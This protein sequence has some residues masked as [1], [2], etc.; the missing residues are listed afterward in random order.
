[1]GA[2]LETT[3]EWLRGVGPD[4]D[5][6]LSTRLRF[7]RNLSRFPFLGGPGGA[8]RAE[9]EAYV[10]DRLAETQK[11]LMYFP[12]HRMDALDRQI[13]VERHLISREH[14]AA[15]GERGAAVSAG[16]SVS[17]MVNEEDH[18]RVQAIRSAFQAEEAFEELAAFEEDLEKR[19]EF[20]FHPRFG[21]AT[22]CPTNLGTGLR[23]SVMLHLPGL[24]YSRQ[25][26]KILHSLQ[27]V[28]YNIRGFFG[29]GTSP[30]GDLFQISNQVCLGRTEREIVEDLKRFVPEIVG[31]ERG[32]RDRLHKD[33]RPFLEDK[34]W[35]ALAVLKNA[36]IL[37]TEETMELLSAVRLGINLGIL[38]GLKMDRINEIFLWSQPAHLQK[39]KGKELSEIERDIFRAEFIREKLKAA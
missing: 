11:K 39:L 13:L 36:R 35:R 38:T 14:A 31:V 37:S 3:G 25:V 21:Y 33:R 1:M 4:A 30:T 23:A 34:A 20:S 2:L 28:H 22:C 7:A 8:S 12:L 27:R 6:V 19:M 29:E 10:Q 26:E 5:V 17:V 16:E 32:L 24:V 18:L 9:I 15:E